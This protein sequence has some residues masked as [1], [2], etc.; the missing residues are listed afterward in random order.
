M[1]SQEQHNFISVFYLTADLGSCPAGWEQRAGSDDCYLITDVNDMR[2]RD[3]AS[4][5]CQKQQGHL[6]KIDSIAE[7]VS[8]N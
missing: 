6:V 7:R 5:E 3:E 1:L 8:N 4:A 2:T